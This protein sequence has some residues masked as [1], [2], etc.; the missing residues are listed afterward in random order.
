MFAKV[1]KIKVAH[2]FAGHDALSKLRTGLPTSKA[3]TRIFPRVWGVNL[4]LPFP[5]PPFSPSL[6]SPSLV[7]PCLLQKSS[8]PLLPSLRSRTPQ[9]QLGCLGSAVSSPTGSG[10]GAPAEI[11]FGAF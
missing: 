5:P 10:G 11:E 2:F 7:L 1:M 8:P 6:S 3:V 9:I 4:T